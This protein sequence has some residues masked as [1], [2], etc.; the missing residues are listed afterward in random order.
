MKALGKSAL[1]LQT[2]NV[3]EFKTNLDFGLLSG[4]QIQKHK[5]LFPR[6]EDND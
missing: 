6:I 2:L 1:Y 4:N 3:P 5:A